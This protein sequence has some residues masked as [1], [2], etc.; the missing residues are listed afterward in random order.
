MHRRILPTLLMAGVTTALL[1]TTGHAQIRSSERGSVS[2]TLDGTTLT[3]GYARP[4]AHDRDLFGALVPYD[5]PWTGANWATT[6][7]T[8]KDVRLNG[9]EVPAGRYSVWIVPREADWTVVLD[10]RAEL[11]H[12]QKPD[13]TPDQIRFAATPGSGS[14]VERLTWTF[15]AVE[16][17]AAMLRMAWGT[18]TLPIEVL[19][20]P[21][22]PATLTADERALYLGS[23]ELSIIEGVGWPTEARI[24]VT[25]QDGRLRGWMPFP[26]HPGDELEFDLVPAGRG[27]F[28]PGL[29]RDGE[30][31]NIEMGGTFEFEFGDADVAT[32]VRIR[33]IEGTVFGEGA[34]IGDASTR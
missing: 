28:S 13:S 1:P 16:G 27:R 22:R 10:L 14:H 18:T 25:E 3:V 2:Q 21:S 9:T 23:Y 31:V 12:F 7:E 29:Y 8:D 26:F 17:D 24:E 6:L 32:H 4:A 34:R 5:I 19:V 20:Q 30:L 15:P 11:F 33:G